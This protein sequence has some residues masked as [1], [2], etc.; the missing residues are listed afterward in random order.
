MSF[1]A[2][3]TIRG[4]ASRQAQSLGL[5]FCL[6]FVASLTFATFIVQLGICQQLAFPGAEG[7]G[8]YVTGGRGGDVYHVTTLEDSGAGSLRYGL[9]S[10]TGKPRTIVFDIGGPIV[11][12][13]QLSVNRSNIT[14]AGETAPGQ[15]IQLRNYG[16]KVSAPN[17]I[18]RH[19]KVRPG[20]AAKGPSPGFSDDAIS[21][22]ASDIILD[23]VSTAW[24]IDENLS[25]SGDNIQHV[26]VQYSIISEGLSQTGLHHG[27]WKKDYNPGGPN[28]H[29]KGS[30]IKTSKGTSTLSYHHNL[31]SNNDNRNPAV[32]TYLTDQAL[33]VDIRNNVLYNNRNNGY[34]SGASAWV[35]M[36]YVGNYVISGPH[37]TASKAFNAKS[38]NN[39]RI[40]EL[41]NW[42][43]TNKDLVR[44]GSSGRQ[45][46]LGGTYT[47]S[48]TPFAMAPVAT[49]PVMNA[50]DNVLAKAGAFYWN[51]DVVDA[52]LIN[53]VKTQG[54][55]I[56]D[57]QTEVGGYP[58]ISIASR[59]ASWDGDG[60]GMP[61]RWEN[62][63]EGLNPLVP[64]NNGD[65]D[66]DG[67]TNLEEYLHQVAIGHQP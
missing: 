63:V 54:G 65:L 5:V 15:G 27:E 38:P 64:D 34:S 49:D 14:I 53:E 22:R 46:I 19:I 16:L 28:T 12:S 20:D 58:A 24:A 43:D 10:T 35:E 52:R 36:N 30:L 13:K 40:H 59:P 42:I 48:T 60:D 51:R 26:T 17:S 23:H 21:I 18:I 67:Y 8:R 50:Y 62:T 56:I 37:T 4:D 31:W 29:S 66:G 41:D 32:G 7:E 1:V 9:K 3:T 57:S 6:R 61:T 44:D 25:V 45:D 55:G 47:P 39:M 33:Q 11:L 2:P